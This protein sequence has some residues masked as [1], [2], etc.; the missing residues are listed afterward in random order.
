MLSIPRLFCRISRQGFSSCDRWRSSVLLFSVVLF[1]AV[2]QGAAAAEGS[3]APLTIAEVERLALADEP[4]QQ[5]LLESAQAA[6]SGAVAAGQ[7][8][9]PALRF[10]VANFP[11]ESGGFR[12]EG[13]TQLKLGLRQPLPA[14]GTL[15]AKTRKFEAQAQVYDRRA[16]VRIRQVRY[17]ARVAWL[18]LWHGQ[19]AADLVRTTRPQLAH[20]AKVT[21]SLYRVGRKSQQDL[22]QA[23]LELA[24]LDDRL[25]QVADRTEQ[26][27]GELARWIGV[28]SAARPLTETLPDWPGLPEVA[29]LH[30]SV[31]AHPRINVA[32]AVIGGREAT[33]ALAEA[34]YRP[35]WALDLSYGLRDGALP[36][37]EPRSD[38]VSLMLTLDLPLFPGQRQ[39]RKLAQAR[40][41]SRAARFDREELRRRL[42]SELDVQLQ[43]WVL[44]ASRIGRYEEQ[45]LTLAGRRAEAALAAY[46]S[47]TG[48][49]SELVDA[50]VGEMEMRLEY[51]RLMVQQ[52]LTYARIAELGG[53]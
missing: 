1:L 52:G 26:A 37:G 36:S 14:P 30:Q 41:E 33:V 13:M 44:L 38:F 43:T 29:A 40:S 21:L 23:E 34:R 45:I 51:T 8:P 16:D 42:T 48:S 7:L 25:Q 19:K 27:R 11:L 4:G 24:R 22:F 10:G 53:I 6:L 31:L 46:Q 49:F 2:E 18:E 12:T 47:D 28:A 50:T 17:Q 15:R 5:A 20:L 35:D 39:D 3:Q 9:D 32:D